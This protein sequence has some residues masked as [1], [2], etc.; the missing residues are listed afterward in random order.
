MTNVCSMPSSSS[1]VRSIAPSGSFMLRR[2]FSTMGS[3]GRADPRRA[4]GGGQNERAWVVGG[5]QR[6][7][8]T[9]AVKIDLHLIG[10]LLRTSIPLVHLPRAMV[11]FASRR[12]R[13]RCDEEAVSPATL[14]G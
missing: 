10:S 9:V 7:I 13:I 2:M 4:W 1:P 3:T 11:K 12:P 5:Q 8:E 6:G 14:H